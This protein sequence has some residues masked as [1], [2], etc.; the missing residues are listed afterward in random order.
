MV[1][2]LKLLNYHEYSMTEQERRTKKTDIYKDKK[3]GKF[4][5]LNGW[6]KCRCR[7]FYF[8]WPKFVL[9]LKWP[10][11]IFSHKHTREFQT[12]SS[13]VHIYLIDDD[14]DCNHSNES[15]MLCSV[16]T[17]RELQKNKYNDFVV[18]H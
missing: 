11:V 8:I 7:H 4:Q 18:V 3:N 9:T 13:V 17:N 14:S 6:T 2:S 16:Q 5:N 12:G 10:L 1:L 15:A